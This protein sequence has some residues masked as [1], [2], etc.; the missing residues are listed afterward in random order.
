MK[1]IHIFVKGEVQNVGYRYFALNKAIELGINGIVLN[2]PDGSVKIE[3]E[4]DEQK[5]NK[6]IEWCR[7][8]PPRALVEN[9]EIVNTEVK[10]YNSFAIAYL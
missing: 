10:N 4:G 2:M 9:I 5:L 6:Y 1:S 3:A 8:G 7:I